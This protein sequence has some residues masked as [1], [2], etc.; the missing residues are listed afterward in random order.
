MRL[1]RTLVLSWITAIL[2][3]GVSVNE[4]WFDRSGCACGRSSDE[5][6]QESLQTT[7]DI[8][9]QQIATVWIA[10]DFE[11]LTS[12]I[13]DERNKRLWE[14]ADHITSTHSGLLIYD[15]LLYDATSHP[16]V[17]EGI[18]YTQLSGGSSYLLEGYA[19]ASRTVSFYWLAIYRQDALQKVEINNPTPPTR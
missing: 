4:F 16:I 9:S 7:Q 2:M 12:I 14:L 1:S 18:Y 11:S 13:L 17:Q 19:K 10:P 5:F 15:T 6:I 8:I 3:F